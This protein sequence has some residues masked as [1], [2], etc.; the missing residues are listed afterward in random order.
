MVMSG[1]ESKLPI[2]SLEDEGF[3][4]ILKKAIKEES[5]R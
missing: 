2:M 4:A 5:C 3:M 1:D